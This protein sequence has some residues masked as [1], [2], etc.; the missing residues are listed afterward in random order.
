MMQSCVVV[1]PETWR[2]PTRKGL[3]ADATFVSRV[4][5]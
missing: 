4:L 2:G 3:F 1:V 5:R